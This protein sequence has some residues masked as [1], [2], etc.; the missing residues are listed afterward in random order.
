[1]WDTSL[2][3]RA[4]GN[5]LKRILACDGGG[6]GALFTLQVLSRMEELFRAERQRPNLVLRDEFDL[7]A[8]TSTGAII[9]T[10][11]AWGMSVRDIESMYVDRS[12]E[13]FARTTWYE[14]LK[15]KYRAGAIARLFQTVFCED[16]EARTP[17]CLGTRKLWKGDTPTYLLVVMRNASTGS[18][19]PITNNP[20][21][22]FNDP[23]HPECNLHIPLWR[24]L[25]AS[26]AAPTYFPPE[27]L[28]LGGRTH[29][30]V[31]GGITPFNN[32]ALIAVLTATLPC[33]R[34]EWPAGTEKLFVA[35]IGTGFERIRYRKRHPSQVT[36]LDHAW[37][38]PSALLASTVQEQDL[39]C[40]ILGDCR[41]GAPIDSEIGD[42]A[43][44]T[45]LR[46]DE[47]KFTYV[48]YNRL[49][50]ELETAEMTRRTGQEFTLDNITLIPY[51]QEVGRA[52]AEANVRREHLFGGV[53][54]DTA[55][56][57]PD[58][59]SI[60]ARPPAWTAGH[61]SSVPR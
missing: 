4:G 48:R 13:M 35:S 16:D 60:A 39:V 12:R 6:I 29:M 55:S 30:F 11:L 33:Y 57:M 20:R 2:I 36:L 27:C 5:G 1:M 3:Q 40:R 34:I 7:F 22:V 44:S 56:Q 31:D 58:S 54:R 14:R 43:G 46:T 32:P 41:A 38:V 53:T 51:L 26:T 23:A 19:W 49:F 37:F 61:G 21:A 59:G 18:P 17:A 24:L 9:A 50:P 52:Y 10:G 45:L 47:K 15:S 25:R 42:L 8:G 28:E